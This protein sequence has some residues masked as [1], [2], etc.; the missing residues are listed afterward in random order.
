MKYNKLLG[1]ILDL[2]QPCVL[3]RQDVRKKSSLCIC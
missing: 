1:L 2:A 3:L